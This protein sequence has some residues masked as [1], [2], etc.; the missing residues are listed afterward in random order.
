MSEK[1]TNWF[2][3]RTVNMENIQTRSDKTGFIPVET[4][5][6]RYSRSPLPYLTSLLND[7]V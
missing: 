5:T 4:R 1:Y 3:D 6:R 7:K 2:V